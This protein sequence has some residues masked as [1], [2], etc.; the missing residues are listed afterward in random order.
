M[1]GMWAGIETTALTHTR[2]VFAD[3]A[4]DLAAC[5]DAH[6]P[7][8]QELIGSFSEWVEEI[9]EELKERGDGGEQN[10]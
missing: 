9:D 5:R 8:I 1:A 6:M 7:G 3:A 2:N 4:E 10:P